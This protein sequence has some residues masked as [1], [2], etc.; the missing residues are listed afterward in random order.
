MRLP[1]ANTTKAAEAKA[2]EV[3]ELVELRV[4][5][6][7][8]NK[9]DINKY[10]IFYIANIMVNKGSLWSTYFIK[11]RTIYIKRLLRANKK[12][13]KKHDKYKN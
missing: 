2:K 3:A 12:V 10:I 11:W 4:E 13:L 7:R 8:K 6:E 9:I 5:P 1:S